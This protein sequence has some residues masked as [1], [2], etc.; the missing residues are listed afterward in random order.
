MSMV[1]RVEHFSLETA[2]WLERFQCECRGAL[3]RR[4]VVSPVSAT[5]G[6]VSYCEFQIEICREGLASSYASGRLRRRSVLSRSTRS[7][8]AAHKNSGEVEWNNR[9]V[10]CMVRGLAIAIRH[11]CPNEPGQQDVPRSPLASDLISKL[12]CATGHRNLVRR[13]YRRGSRYVALIKGHYR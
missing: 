10:S 6:F 5:T 7:T 4:P 3:V 8:L 13:C 1:N 9:H 12:R 2:L 11:I